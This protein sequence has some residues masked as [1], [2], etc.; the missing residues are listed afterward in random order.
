MPRKLR[1]IGIDP[2]SRITGYAVICAEGT[3]A[4]SVRYVECGVLALDAR[5]PL[6][7][8][9][10]ELFEGTTEILRELSPHVAAV[11]DVFYGASVRSALILGQ[12]RGAALAALGS[13]GVRVF[14][15]PPATIK[16]AVT[17]R[18]RASKVQVAQMVRAIVG[19]RRTPRADAADAL[20]VAVTHALLRTDGLRQPERWLA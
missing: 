10:A 8:R 7:R 17:G 20:A 15:Y 13:A 14:A 6:E 5:A 18:G 3:R 16:Q 12:A 9:L 11:E 1:I 19:L 4:P 2:G